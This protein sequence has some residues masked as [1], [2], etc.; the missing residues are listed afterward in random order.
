MEAGKNCLNKERFLHPRGPVAGEKAQLLKAPE[1]KPD[2][3]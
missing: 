3:I 1:G 2:H